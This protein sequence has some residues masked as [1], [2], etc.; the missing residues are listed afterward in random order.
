MKLARFYVGGV[1]STLPAILP[2]KASR[3]S[4]DEREEEI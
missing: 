2:R 4:R 1:I 3:E